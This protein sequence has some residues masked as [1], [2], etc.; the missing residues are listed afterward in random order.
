MSQMSPVDL[1]IVKA[2]PGNKECCDCGQKNPQ[3]AS[4]SFGNVFCLECSGI[5]RSL[6]VH[7]SFVRSIAMDSWTEKQLALMKNGGNKKCNDY[8]KLKG[9]DPRTPVKAKY[10]SNHAQLFKEILKARVEGRPEPTSL[11]PPKK[12][13]R[14]TCFCSTEHGWWWWND[15]GKQGSQR[16]GT[17]GRRNRS[18]VHITTN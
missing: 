5:H 6:G 17:N 12:K 7:I 14:G 18:T 10:E 13:S 3:W 15:D 16:N 4:V 8:L 2:L 11:P 1:A 9:V